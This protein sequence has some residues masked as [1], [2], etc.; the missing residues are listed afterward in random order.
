MTRTI[1][2][3]VLISSVCTLA[4]DRLMDAIRQD[5]DEKSSAPAAPVKPEAEVDTDTEASGGHACMI[6]GVH[7]GRRCAF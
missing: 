4:C 7:E 6:T 5:S 1:H 2:C 3:V